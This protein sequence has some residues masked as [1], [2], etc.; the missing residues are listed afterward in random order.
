MW[1]LAHVWIFPI[2][3]SFQF[4]MN[5]ALS[6]CKV[7]WCCLLREDAG[8]RLTTY[9]PFCGNIHANQETKGDISCPPPPPPH[10]MPASRRVGRA[11]TPAERNE[12]SLAGEKDQNWSV[13]SSW[14]IVCLFLPF[15][16]LTLCC[17]LWWEKGVNE[18]RVGGYRQCPASFTTPIPNEKKAE[19]ASR[20][21][22]GAVPTSIT[23][24]FTCGWHS[25]DPGWPPNENAHQKP[26]LL[27]KPIPRC[28]QTAHGPL[29]H[30]QPNE[31]SALM[32]PLWALLVRQQSA[33][34]TPTIHF[35]D[36][37]VVRADNTGLINET[38]LVSWRKRRGYKSATGDG[39]QGEPDGLVSCWWDETL[40]PRGTTPPAE[41]GSRDIYNAKAVLHET[42]GGQNG[43][44]QY[45]VKIV[46]HQ[47]IQKGKI[48]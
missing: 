30:C 46:L 15:S 44:D 21:D 8:L 24:L 12:T 1:T 34:K 6:R 40:R 2:A 28:Q 14:D 17:P 47:Y 18:G 27:P 38:G 22:T 10:Q 19:G 32:K 43:W 23:H 3:T 29:T 37:A 9:L 20:G 13:S 7:A 36:W 5:A 11:I 33:M 41:C 39:I 25:D 16:F 35:M 31:T 42:S 45:Y 26:L 48:V 4:K